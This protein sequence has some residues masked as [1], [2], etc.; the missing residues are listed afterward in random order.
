M[1]LPEIKAALRKLRDEKIQEQQDEQAAHVL[2][3]RFLSEVERLSEAKGLTRKALA[4]AVGTS[5]SY[6]TQLFRGDRTLNLLMAA[7]L[8]RALGA[9]FHIKAVTPITHSTTPEM[10]PIMLR[11][12]PASLRSQRFIEQQAQS[13]GQ[14]D[15]YLA[16]TNSS[17]KTLIDDFS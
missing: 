12:M 2:S 14:Y 9:E 4:E 17:V 7:R 6:I 15:V 3:F 5:A 1:T 16:P 10:H 11:K 13:G 8:Q